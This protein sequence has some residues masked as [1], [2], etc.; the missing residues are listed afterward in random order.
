MNFNSFT[1]IVM[2]II[3]DTSFSKIHKESGSFC[4]LLASNIS[5]QSVNIKMGNILEK[6]WNIYIANV[7]GVKLDGRNIIAGSQVDILFYYKDVAY[8]LES[9]N[10]L[11]IDTEKTIA[12]LNKVNKII[13]E[14]KKEGYTVVGKILNNRYPTA[15]LAKFYKTPITKEH[16][17]GYSELFNIF[18]IVVTQQEWEAF[19]KKVGTYI[20]N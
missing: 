13:D 9:K 19:F 3:R 8:Y 17:I 6:A 16:I 5:Q 18:G 2:S 15:E 10:N 7:D 1:Q 14:L 12:T 11:N 20:Y 4:E